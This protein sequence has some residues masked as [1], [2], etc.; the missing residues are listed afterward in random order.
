VLVADIDIP[1]GANDR[2]GDEARAWRADIGDINLG[3]FPRKYFAARPAD[4]TG[5]TWRDDNSQTTM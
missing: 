4:A 2:V 3:A 5:P 1:T